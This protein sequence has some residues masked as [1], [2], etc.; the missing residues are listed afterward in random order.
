MRRVNSKDKY[1]Y[2]AWVTAR[3]GDMERRV[4]HRPVHMK[5]DSVWRLAEAEWQTS[6]EGLV[7]SAVTEQAAV[8][9]ICWRRVTLHI[10]LDVPASS[11]LSGPQLLLLGVCPGVHREIP[12]KVEGLAGGGLGCELPPAI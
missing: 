5:G 2:R 7:A 4:G 10:G 6:I 11:E 1:A 12:C 8:V 3:A 9:V